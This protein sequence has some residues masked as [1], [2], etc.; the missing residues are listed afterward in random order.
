MRATGAGSRAPAVDGSREDRYLVAARP[1][2]LRLKGCPTTQGSE[3]NCRFNEIKR[4]IYI[5]IYVA[6]VCM[7]VRT[8][9]G[10]YVCMH[11]CMYAC[12]HACM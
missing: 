2:S 7:Y 1:Y 10:M 6:Y 4:Q 9:V 12:M 3:V 8:Y 11:V 5:Y